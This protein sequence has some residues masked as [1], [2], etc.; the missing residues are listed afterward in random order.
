MIKRAGIIL[1][2][3]LFLAL[4]LNIRFDLHYCHDELTEISFSHDEEHC[5]GMMSNDCNSCKDVHV[6]FENDQDQ[7]SQTLKFDFAIIEIPSFNSETVF[8]EEVLDNEKTVV[9][10]GSDSSPPKLYKLY[11]QFCFYG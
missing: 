10:E 8:V 2:G 5:G 11:S 6:E 9:L 1:L 7:I 3:T 4:S